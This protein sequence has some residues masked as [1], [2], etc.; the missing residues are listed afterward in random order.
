MRTDVSKFSVFE[1]EEIVLAAKL[2]QLLDDGMSEVLQDVYVCLKAL[3][4]ISGLPAY[5]REHNCLDQANIWTNGVNDCKEVLRFGSVY[6]DT[7]ICLLPLNG[8]KKVHCCCIGECSGSF[9][10]RFFVCSRVRHRGRKYV[11]VFCWREAE[12]SEEIR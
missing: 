8:F 4:S 5:I 7:E 2:F 9:S 1:D 3:L 11:K 12:G 6:A 10:I